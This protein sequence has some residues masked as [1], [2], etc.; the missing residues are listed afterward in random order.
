MKF[1]EFLEAVKRLYE[2]DGVDFDAM[3]DLDNLKDNYRGLWYD[4]DDPE[5]AYNK[6]T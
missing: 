4:G 5:E 2:Q 6:L 3:S 1:S